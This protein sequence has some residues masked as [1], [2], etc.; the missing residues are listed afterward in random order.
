MLGEITNHTC[1]ILVGPQGC[2]KTT[3][4]NN[5]AVN[6]H[7]RFTGTINPE[8]KDSKFKLAE[9]GLINLD[10]IESS[11]RTEWSFIKSL[12]TLIC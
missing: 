12:L 1:L 3:F 6:H 4:L 2:G 7:Y 10:E 11:T 8:N 9:C 5:L